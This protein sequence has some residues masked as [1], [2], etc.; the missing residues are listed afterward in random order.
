MATISGEPK[1]MCGEKRQFL[2]SVRRPCA[3]GRFTRPVIVGPQ[4][5]GLFAQVHQHDSVIPDKKITQPSRHGRHV[6]AERA[7]PLA[8][9]AAIR[10]MFTTPFPIYPRSMYQCSNG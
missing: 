1:Q 7:E 6:A 10:N 3:L 2:G 9:T 4:V 8:G 5:L